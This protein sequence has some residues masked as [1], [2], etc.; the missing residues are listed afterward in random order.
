[1]SSVL[2]TNLLCLPDP[3]LA[4]VAPNIYNTRCHQRLSLDEDDCFIF[5]AHTHSFV[6]EV[7]GG[8]GPVVHAQTA[9]EDGRLPGV[10]HDVLSCE[11]VVAEELLHPAGSHLKLHVWLFMHS[12]EVKKRSVPEEG[13]LPHLLHGDVFTGAT[14]KQRIV[15]QS[16][17]DVLLQWR[18]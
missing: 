3:E 15:L 14:G 13:Q 17:E 10:G 8:H 9:V 18:S 7:L 1:M 12:A 5:P 6:E 16:P 4:T 11:E 2:S